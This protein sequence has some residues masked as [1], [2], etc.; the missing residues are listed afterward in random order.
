MTKSG[1]IMLE[2]YYEAAAKIYSTQDILDSYKVSPLSLFDNQLIEGPVLDVGCG[3]ASMLLCFSSSGRD[4]YAVDNGESALTA[5][6][7]RVDEV[8]DADLTKWHFMKSDVLHDQVPEGEFALISMINLLHFFSDAEREEILAKIHQRTRPGSMVC[9]TVNSDKHSANSA[10][11]TNRYAQF[12]HF[13]TEEDL[14]HSFPNQDFQ[15]YYYDYTHRKYSTK[16]L[17][18]MELWGR[19]IALASENPGNKEWVDAYAT[20]FRK[21]KEANE[22]VSSLTAI[23]IRR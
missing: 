6:R 7:R 17:D 16:E 23:F 5:L 13:F 14:S 18:V 22:T 20:R 1:S 9:V 19:K 11:N 3:P 8:P 10:G 2:L 4:L 12:K 15:R 21:G